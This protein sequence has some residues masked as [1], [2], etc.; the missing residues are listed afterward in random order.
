[1]QRSEFTE[2][3]ILTEHELEIGRD[4]GGIMVLLDGLVP[5]TPLG[6]VLPVGDDI[7]E[8][9]TLYNRPDLMSIYGIAREVAALLETD[10][11]AM[12]GTEP[13]REG[14]EPVAIAIEDLD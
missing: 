6:E 7:L 10:L 2:G 3:M 14:D 9:E 13:V 4:Q 1:M 8:I 5:G 11:R 12:P